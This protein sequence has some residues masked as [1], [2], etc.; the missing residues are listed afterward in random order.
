[1]SALETVVDLRHRKLLG[2]L[3]VRRTRKGWA[4]LFFRKDMPLSPERLD[5]ASL[6]EATSVAEFLGINRLRVEIF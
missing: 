2:P 5:V 3:T 6:D 4:M 1:M